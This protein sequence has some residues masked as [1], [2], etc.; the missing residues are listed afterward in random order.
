MW[1][2]IGQDKILSLLDYSL[3]TNAVAHAYLLVGPRHVGKGTLAINLAQ[4]LNCDGPEVPCGQCRSCQRIREGKHADV[5]PIGLD[6]RTEIGIDDIRGLQRSAN[7]PPYEGKCKVFIIDEAEY[8]S[9]EAANSLLKILEEPP[10]R[11]VW[12]LLAAEEGRLLPTVIS[13][14]Q[15][16]ELKPVPSDRVQQVLINSY[17][18]DAD[19]AKL[20]NQL[21]HGR[22]GWAVSALT[23]DDILQKRSQRIDKL[24]S[25]LTASLEQRFAYA[26]E[27]ASQFSQDRKAGMD[28]IEAWLDWW[29]D[30]MLIRGGCKEA[31]INVD[32]ETVLEEQAGGLSLSEI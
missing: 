8:L 7:L 6:S 15:R 3:R 12:L 5:I 23:N 24:V 9:T 13:R 29:R 27:L 31:I 30:L 18:V 17:N 2:V 10:P 22:L 4:A 21:C 28:I 16:L 1:Q 32:Y 25:L 14:C 11:V 19:K 26:Q 20:L